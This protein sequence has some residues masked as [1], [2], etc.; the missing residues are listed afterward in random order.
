MISGEKK[1]KFQVKKIH[2]TLLYPAFSI[3]KKIKPLK[4]GKNGALG[5]FEMSR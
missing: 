3:L 2:E 5:S 4:A 1:E